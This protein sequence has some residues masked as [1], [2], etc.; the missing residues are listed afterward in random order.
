MAGAPRERQAS[1]EFETSE[2]HVQDGGTDSTL[3]AEIPYRV[4][5]RIDARVARSWK[6]VLLG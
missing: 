6:T 3:A 4:V 1:K 5:R 2:A